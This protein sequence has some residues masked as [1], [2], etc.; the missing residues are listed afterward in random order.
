[1]TQ[2]SA[3]CGLFVLTFKL[4]TGQPQGLNLDSV[5]S[6]LE[7]IM[8]LARDH[9]GCSPDICYLGVVGLTEDLQCMGWI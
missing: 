7:Y 8:F 9:G 4:V 1:M 6:S 2:N 3:L 5:D